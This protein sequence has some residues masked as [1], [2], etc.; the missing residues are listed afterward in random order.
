MNKT[1]GEVASLCNVT[2]RTVQYY[3]KKGVISPSNTSEN[4]RRLYTEEDINQLRLVLTL[5]DMN[6]SLKEI[7]ELLNSNH[8]INTLNI[9]LSEKLLDLENG[10]QQQTEQVEQIKFIRENISKESEYPVS[11]VLNLKNKSKKHQEMKTFRRKFMGT[12]LIV[13]AFQ[14][15]SII[16]SIMKK[17]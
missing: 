11:N 5:K 16:T 9:L 4:N 15:S 10:I 6:F 7:K 1:T 8:S 13:G 3:D 2:V 17:K 14:Y 12:S